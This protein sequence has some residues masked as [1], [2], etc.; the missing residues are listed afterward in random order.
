MKFL[1]APLVF[2]ILALFAPR[3]EAQTCSATMSAV[4]FGSPNIL[5]GATVDT[6]GTLS[7]TCQNLGAQTVRV[8]PS[9]GSGSGGT[10]GTSRRMTGS[11]GSL[12][13]YDLYQDN[14]RTQKW[15]SSTDASLG[16]VPTFNIVSVDNSII[17]ANYVVYARLAASQNT[18]PPGSYASNYGVSD[19]DVLFNHGN[20]C[21]GSAVAPAGHPTFA[22][23]ATPQNYCTISVNDLPFGSKG[24]L[25]AVVD[26]SAVMSVACTMSTAYAISLDNGLTGTSPTNRLMTRLGQSVAYG[27]YR[28]AARSQSWST[29]AAGGAVA[30]TGTGVSQSVTVYGR[31]PVQQTPAPGIY[32]D[33]VVA[34][35][36]F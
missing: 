12:L 22:V 11:S 24:V 6:T 15:G 28:N 14:A 8:C 4:N 7:V 9:L 34:T 18:Q 32:A 13:L 19:T 17:T 33:T 23:S 36:E 20:G 27:L 5:A 30:G 3:A 16:T 35:V 31:V 25:D 2:L 10:S 21:G 26:A 1:L 29:V